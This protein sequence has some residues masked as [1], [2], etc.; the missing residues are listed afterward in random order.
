MYAASTFPDL[1]DGAAL[2]FIP[3]RVGIVSDAIPYALIGAARAAKS[4]TP[5]PAL[6]PPETALPRVPFPQRPWLRVLALTMS[7]ALHLAAAAAMLA[8]LP[9]MMPTDVARGG[10]DAPMDV[11]IV[12]A[13]DFA[14]SQEGAKSEPVSLALSAVPEP[15]PVDIPVE[16]PAPE[17]IPIAVPP[18]EPPVAPA[19]PTEA[20]LLPSPR[21]LPSLPEITPPAKREVPRLKKEAVK[22]KPAKKEPRPRASTSLARGQTGAGES[23]TTRTATSRGGSSGAEQTAGASAMSGY[24]AR[25]IAHLNR[26]KNYPDQARDRGISG[27]NAITLTLGRDG[28]VIASSLANS[29]GQSLLD[30]ATLAAARR[31]QPFPAMPESGPTSFTLTIGMNYN[32]R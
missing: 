1:K 22:E 9:A 30:S 31:A 23:A 21:E 20:A 10:A 12:G 26:F 16:R 19:L 11:L 2:T 24:R 6:S 17:E 27:Q 32:L 5:A 8:Y 13:A 28:R 7:T 14:A 29:S 3:R 18:P 4:E 15:V 25:I